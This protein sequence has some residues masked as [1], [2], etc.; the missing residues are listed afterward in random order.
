ML[1]SEG[2]QWNCRPRVRALAVPIRMLTKS[3]STETPFIYNMLQ[4]WKKKTW[5]DI[6]YFQIHHDELEF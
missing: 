4:I 2:L 3:A 1:Y 5:N 6:L